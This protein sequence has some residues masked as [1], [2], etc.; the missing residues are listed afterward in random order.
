MAKRKTVGAAM[1]N[2]SKPVN[3]NLKNVVSGMGTRRDKRSHNAYDVAR[4]LTRFELDNMYRT[5][6]LSKQ[7]INTVAD[8]MTR[9]WRTFIF[10]DK[11]G[12]M[13]TAIEDFE[14]AMCIPEKVNEALRWSRLYGGSLLILGV[15]RNKN[16]IQLNMS[17][18]LDVSTIKK[19]D[20]KWIHC[21]DRWRCAPSGA[22]T[23]DL[24][25]PNFGL[26]ETYL[27]AESSVQIHHT[28]VIRFNGQKLPWFAWLANSM[29]DDS[30]LQHVFDSVSDCDMAIQQAASMLFE[31][32]VD[33]IKSPTINELLATAEGVT[34]VIERFTN[35]QMMKSNNRTL[36]LGADEEYE[37]K[38][39][40]FAGV[41]DVIRQ[42]MVF[43]S[44]AAEIPMI[45]LFGQSAP[46]MN[47]TGETDL[48]TYYDKV[49]KDQGVHL[50]PQLEYLDEIMLR[51][52][53]GSVPENYRFELDPLWQI[54]DVEQSTIQKNN[55]D[56]DK[57]YWDMG[58]L[59]ELNIAKEL[60]EQG[61]YATLTQDDIDELEQM[62]E[63]NAQHEELLRTAEVEQIGEGGQE[64]TN[65]ANEARSGVAGSKVAE[66]DDPVKEK[67]IRGGSNAP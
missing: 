25:S 31:A 57:N 64:R 49:K 54:S 18:P 12:D 45:K 39:N 32:N 61:V 44:G 19:G 20:L 55:S 37:K 62:M 46:G 11:Q 4:V 40:S 9:E 23:M 36:L 35:S 60:K 28:R 66:G 24:M 59:T 6:W 15:G 13:A 48:R 3:D 22:R 53:F 47:A 65:Q 16:D 43:V 52:L 38:N 29:W 50:R 10:D 30:E 1:A 8:D 34:R 5:S 26:P 67:G 2:T 33:V 63:I 27:L 58:V 14:K 17:K 51:H 7:I 21:V 41:P 56:R 42:A